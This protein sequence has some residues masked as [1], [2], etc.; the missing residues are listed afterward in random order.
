MGYVGTAMATLIASSKL[1]N[2]YRYFV[3]GIEQNN[4]NGIKISREINSGI[5][6]IQT[7]DKNFKQKFLHA[8]KKEKNYQLE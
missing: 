1:G 7:N 4:K 8:T 2:S 6:P 3:N 5:I